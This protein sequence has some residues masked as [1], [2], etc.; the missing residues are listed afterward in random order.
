MSAAAAPVAVKLSEAVAGFPGGRSLEGSFCAGTRRSLEDSPYVEGK[1][2]WLSRVPKI[3]VRN[4]GVLTLQ[5]V[6]NF[7]SV[8]EG[9][10]MDVI[11]AN[12]DIIL[13]RLSVN[14]IVTV[15]RLHTNIDLSVSIHLRIP[16]SAFMSSYFHSSFS[17][18]SSF[19]IHINII[20]AMNMRRV[21]IICKVSHVTITVLSSAFNM[22]L[23]I[24]YWDSILLALS[25]CNITHYDDT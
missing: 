1:N 11:H 16:L 9:L 23:I 5:F 6:C 20:R 12:I 2:T 10:N 17:H 13:S 7:M 22:S 21:R 15:S 4:E 24:L 14:I 8:S 19:M 18:G 25:P 3:T